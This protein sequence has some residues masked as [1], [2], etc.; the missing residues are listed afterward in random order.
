MPS[1]PP[2]EEEE[3]SSQITIRLRPSFL[4]RLEGMGGKWIPRSSVARLA[5]ELGLKAI[6]ADPRLLE[7]AEPAKTGPKP[8][9]DRKPPS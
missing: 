7:Q 5:L 2:P 9:K 1:E 4:G 3:L 8:K 6:E